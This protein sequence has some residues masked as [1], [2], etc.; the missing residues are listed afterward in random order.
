MM[1]IVRK[2][3]KRKLEEGKETAFVVRKRP[4][5]PR[6]IARFVKYHDI[7]DFRSQMSREFFR[8]IQ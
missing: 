7:P 2:D 6:K 5:D 3:R 8:K 4:V 1:A